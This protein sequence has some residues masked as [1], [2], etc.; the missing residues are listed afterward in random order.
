[1]QQP[2]HPAQ[3]DRSPTGHSAPPL[4]SDA[5]CTGARI[6]DSGR[7]MSAQL[8]Q[9]GEALK[10]KRVLELGAGTGIGKTLVSAGL[11]HELS[12]SEVKMI[13]MMQSKYLWD[14]SDTIGSL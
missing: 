3:R 14:H 10:G 13:L 4:S 11:C 9:Q 1:M 12:H 5:L 2:A 7:E 8:L 6:W